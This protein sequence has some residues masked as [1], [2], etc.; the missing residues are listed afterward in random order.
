MS[1]QE[2]KKD[3]KGGML[4]E[5]ARPNSQMWIVIAL[6]VAIVGIAIISNSDNMVRTTETQFKKMLASHDI[7]KILMINGQQV[8]ITLKDESLKNDKYAKDLEK[9]KFFPFGKTGAHYY[10]KIVSGE[11][12]KEELDKI[13][14]SFKEEDVVALEVDRRTDGFGILLRHSIHPYDWRFLVFDASNDRWWRFWIATI[15]HW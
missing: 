9:N 3:K 7:K 12:F 14:K 15:Q 8:E 13:Q 10:F 4:P 5:G 6:L 2:N 1:D 11:S